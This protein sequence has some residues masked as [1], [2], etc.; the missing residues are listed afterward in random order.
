[1]ALATVTVH[2]EILNPDGLTPATGTVQFTIMHKLRDVVDNIVYSP[3]TFM[4]TLDLNGEFTIVLPATD[5]PDLIPADW[6][7]RIFI[8]ATTWTN[9]FYARIPFAPGVTEFADL[10]PVDF[11]SCTGAIDG[12]VVVPSDASLFV[13]K[14]GDTMTG[15]LIIDANLQV[16]GAAN[17]D[18]TLTTPFTGVS[19]DVA[20]LLA[21][22]LSTSIISGGDMTPNVDPTKIDI[23]ATTGY[24]VTYNS[25]APLSPT[26][27]DLKFVSV[28]AQVGLTPTFNPSFFK[29]DSAGTY[30]Q[31]ST[32]LTPTQR[33]THLFVGFTAQDGLGNIV[34]DQTLPVTPSQ[35]NNQLLD[36]MG[37]LGPFGTQGNVLSANGVNLN[38]NKTSGTM[39]ARA[40]SQIPTFQDPHNAP[41][42]AQTPAQF[43]H[44]TAVAGTFGALTTTLDVANYDPGGLGVITPVGGGANTATNFRVYGF[45]NNLANVQILVQYGQNTYTSLANAV[46]ALGAGTFIPNPSSEGGAILGWITAIRTATNLSNPA[47]ATFTQASK[48]AH[49]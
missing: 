40:F 27:P 29:I 46:A 30:T 10:I 9:Q 44:V 28:P 20:R 12:I 6:V 24:I 17:V 47:Q 34:V 4:A 45:A 16:S 11:D 23:S 2:G 15:N 41:L 32:T 26:N 31:Q 36:L 8:N 48:F 18:G 35:L 1:M 13:L 19:L 43:R 33:R 14:A 22:G 42:P 49:P 7:Y 3:T 25:S 38:F 37:A 39:F 21:I 5:N